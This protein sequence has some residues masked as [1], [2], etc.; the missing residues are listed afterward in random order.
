MEPFGVSG[1]I[2]ATWG[3][4]ELKPRHTRGHPKGHPKKAIKKSLIANVVT[5][6]KAPVTTSVALVTTSV[7]PVTA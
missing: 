7:A 1:A 3:T 4:D 5:T 2:A 6:S